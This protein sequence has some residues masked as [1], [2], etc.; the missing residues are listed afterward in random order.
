MH[1]GIAPLITCQN[2]FMGNFQSRCFMAHGKGDPQKFYSVGKVFGDL[3]SGFLE[4]L[5]PPDTWQLLPFFSNQWSSFYCGFCALCSSC[6]SPTHFP[7]GMDC[8]RRGVILMW[9]PPRDNSIM[10]REIVS[11]TVGI[12]EDFENMCRIYSVQ[13]LLSM[14]RLRK[15]PMR[16]RRT[17][18]HWSTAPP[19][20]YSACWRATKWSPLSRRT[21]QLLT[22]A[23]RRRSVYCETLWKRRGEFSCINI[24]I[25]Q[26]SFTWCWSYLRMWRM[27]CVRVLHH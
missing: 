8:A 24:A 23:W 26:I 25:W 20:A 5:H 22:R 12:F 2:Q 10:I 14:V 7:I 21:E 18:K 19:Q 27:K 1:A 13:S 15:A 17:W 3:K 9:Q 16:P 6:W 11:L 4:F